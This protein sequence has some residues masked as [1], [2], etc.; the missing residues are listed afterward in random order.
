MPHKSKWTAKRYSPQTMFTGMAILVVITSLIFIAILVKIG[1]NQAKAPIV[2]EKP[3]KEDRGIPRIQAEDVDLSQL[4]QENFYVH[5]LEIAPDDRT[6]AMGVRGIGVVIW[7][8]GQN[9]VRPVKLLKGLSYVFPIRFS[10]KNHY[11]YLGDD[12][13]NS[14]ILNTTSWTVHQNISGGRMWPPVG[15]AF[16]N[17]ASQILLM[18]GNNCYELWDVASGNQLRVFHDVQQNISFNFQS[19]LMAE[20]TKD[21]NRFY[22]Y[23]CGKI[24]E[25]DIE[26][27]NST[28]I[29]DLNVRSPNPFLPGFFSKTGSRLIF[30]FENEK[31]LLLDVSSRESR[32]LQHEGKN[33]P[34][35]AMSPDGNIALTA[36]HDGKI[37]VWNAATGEVMHTIEHPFE[38]FYKIVFTSDRKQVAAFNL[39]E[40]MFAFFDV[41]SGEIT[42]T[43]HFL[44][45]K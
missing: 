18:K 37:L 23:T 26:T 9:Q 7:D 10:P 19:A 45:N 25:W 41:Q 16:S 30:A 11:L 2:Y 39:E 44:N 4:S 36:N 6:V 20:F 3:I 21:G 14:L 33:I 8:I 31:A 12:Q 40:K 13:A 15:V 22:T 5:C 32:I 34:T 17:D 29:F 1:P 24:M 27:G 28:L 43:I 42:R 35:T 38:S